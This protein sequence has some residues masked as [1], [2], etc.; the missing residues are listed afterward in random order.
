MLLAVPVGYLVMDNWL[1]Q[2]DYRIV[3]GPVCV[4][5]HQDCA[6]C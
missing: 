4:H 6:V 1:M 2:F 3:I 5:H